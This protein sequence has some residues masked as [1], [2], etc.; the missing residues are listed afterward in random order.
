MSDNQ[1]FDDPADSFDE[2]EFPDEDDFDDQ[3][4]ETLPCP[5]CG[6]DVYEDSDRCP[7]CG[8]YVVF[9]THPFAGRAWWW[10]AL[11]VL[12]VVSLILTLAIAGAF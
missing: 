1:W 9:S 5:Q 12:G 2:R 6:G 11:G 8:S 7:H 3:P 4:G 10:I